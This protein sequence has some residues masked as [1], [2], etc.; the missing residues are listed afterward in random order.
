MNIHFE[1]NI[2]PFKDMIRII[3]FGGA[4]IYDENHNSKMNRLKYKCYNVVNG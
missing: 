4:T 3:N 1:I 2:F